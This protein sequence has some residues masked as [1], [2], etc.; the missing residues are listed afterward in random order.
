MKL[1]YTYKIIL[2]IFVLSGLTAFVSCQK[3]SE[4]DIPSYISIDSIGLTVAGD[5]GTASNK[6]VDAWVYTDNDLE[7]AFELPAKFPVLKSGESELTIMPG[8]KLNGMSETRVAYP[9]FNPITVPVTLTHEQETQVNT[10]FTTYKSNTVFAWLENFEDPNYTLDTT[11]LSDV[12]FTRIGD[13]A[14]LSQYPGEG[15]SYAAKVILQNESD[16][17]ECISHNDFSFPA[18]SS[19]LE[20]SVFLE[21]NYKTNCA[22][23]VGLYIYGSQT[24]QK[25]IVVINPSKAWNKIYLN[26]TP[27]VLSNTTSTK[28]KVFIRAQKEV[29]GPDAEIL[30]DNIKLLHF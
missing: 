8:I 28:Y 18:H 27:T 24:V 7:G 29:D 15:N 2:Y 22:F 1:I 3:T 23:T 5:Q 10:K 4:L 26:F 17:F 25:P 13:P 14:L 19:D 21:L 6:I 11:E 16:I 12:A 9:F 20:S 30:I